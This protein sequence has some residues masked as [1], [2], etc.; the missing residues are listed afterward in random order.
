MALPLTVVDAFTDRPFSGNPA[1]VCLLERERSES[2]LHDMAREMNLSET[3]FLLAEGDGYR[4]RWFTPTMEVDLCGH[5]TLAAA[6]VLWERDLLDPARQARFFTRS[7]LLTA[8]RKGDWIELDFPAE[9]ALPVESSISLE[10]LLGVPAYLA[11][12]NRMDYLVEVADEDSVFGVQPDF[13]ALARLDCRGIIVTSRAAGGEY[14]FVSRFFAPRAGIPE[15]PVTGSAHCCLGPYWGKK[16]GKR[17]MTGYQAS[18]RGGIVRV[19]LD[20]DR[21]KLGGKA[22]TIWRGELADSCGG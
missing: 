5:A 6:H 7:G 12:K 2:W 22:V 9:P 18:A 14:D 19:E 11:G 8:L 13:D 15:D 20:G 4:L 10:E 3:A 1:A 17:I 21:V 16:L